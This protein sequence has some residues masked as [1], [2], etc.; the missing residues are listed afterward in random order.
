[1][2]TLNNSVLA[3]LF[4]FALNASAHAQATP[5]P[6][7][8]PPPNTDIF[9]ADLSSAAGVPKLGAARRITTWEGYDNQP[10]FTPEGTDILYTSIRADNQADIYRYRLADNS[11]MRLTETEEA[12]YSPTVTPDGKS[13]SVIRVERDREAT[14]RLWKFPLAGAQ[15]ATLVL[16]RFKPV[17]YHVWA[18]ARTLGLFILGQPAT[19][20][21]VDARTGVYGIVATN[22]G[23]SLQR[24]PGTQKITY[25]HKQGTDDWHIKEYDTRTHAKRT[26]AKTLALSEDFAWTPDGTLL[27]AKGA[28]LYALRPGAAGQDWREVAD[29]TSDGLSEITRLSVS[30]R[31]DRLALVARPRDTR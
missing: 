7:P 11:T 23:R 19:L 6:T 30:P 31:G 1:M 22:I 28:K 5:T 27:M 29:F 14:Q 21:V 24:V 20:Q 15:T 12:E 18:D 4:A 16:E 25:V 17:G 10:S 8:T 9:V 2:R 3:I 13:F 26:L